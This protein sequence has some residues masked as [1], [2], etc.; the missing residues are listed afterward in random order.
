MCTYAA[1]ARYSGGALSFPG[2]FF[3]SQFFPCVNDPSDFSLFLVKMLEK[4]FSLSFLGNSN[5]R[6]DEEFR[7]SKPFV[8]KFFNVGTIEAALLQRFFPQSAV[9]TVRS[10]HA[11]RN[12]TNGHPHLCWPARQ[13]VI[14]T[15]AQPRSPS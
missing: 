4:M 6:R 7:L 12:G 1:I 3:V 2:Y 8:S 5:P 13:A 9:R 14:N 15:R 10:G 11:E